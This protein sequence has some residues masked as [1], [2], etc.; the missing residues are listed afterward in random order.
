[1][2]C[3]VCGEEF[4]NSEEMKRHSERAHPM[5]QD[6]GDMDGGEAPDMMES[7]PSMPEMEEAD[8]RTR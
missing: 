8:R 2:K 3:D 7:N 5:G 6:G 4:T 1:M